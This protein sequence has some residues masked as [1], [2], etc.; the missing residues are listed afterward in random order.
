M[1]T[2]IYIGNHEND[3]SPEDLRQRISEF[4]GKWI[5]SNMP[6]WKPALPEYE[7]LEIQGSGQKRKIGL[8]GLNTI[9][10]NLYRPGAFDGAMDTALPVIE[11]AVALRK[12]LIEEEGCD[13]VIP[14]THQIM[15][16][17]RQMAE[18]QLG[19]PLLIGAHD[20]DP[21]LEK[22][23]GATIVKTGADANMAAIIDISWASPD[24]EC[25]INVELVETRLYPPDPEMCA[26]VR[27][28]LKVVD[29]LESAYLAP[30]DPAVLLYSTK[31]R[32][33]PTPI[34][35]MLTSLVRDGFRSATQSAAA[36]DGVMMDA[37]ALR[38]NFEYPEGYTIFTFGD[39]KKEI[40]FPS[41]MVLVS[42]KG[43]VV[44]DAVAASRARAFKD[45]PED[46]GGY[47][48]LDDG[49]KWDAATN[50]VTHVNLE[51]LGH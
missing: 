10:K 9:D 33:E 46:W 27:M 43:S 34:G 1:Y 37:G 11:T 20:H 31:M 22:V 24:S 29:E 25:E 8:L 36:C 41:G 48:Q 4:K 51:P 16:E 12:K 6:A 13:L 7:I 50:L 35:T 42:M 21:Y 47:M 40:P 14:M 3:I 32:R 28:H 5:N 17:D 23:A 39:L 19:F 2:H 38:R 18:A 30:V 15:A 49:F 26:A 45:P 44:R